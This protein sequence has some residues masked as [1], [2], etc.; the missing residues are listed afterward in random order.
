VSELEDTWTAV[1]AVL[2]AEWSV[3]KPTH[4]PD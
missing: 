3:T 4:H 2:P 1:Y